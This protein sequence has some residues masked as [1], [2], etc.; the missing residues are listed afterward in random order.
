MADNRVL[1]FYLT[2]NSGHHRAALALQE[3]LQAARGVDA[4]LVNTLRLTHPFLENIVLSTYV[5]M[6]KSAPEVWDYLYDNHKVK[7]R[8]ELFQK[9]V[10]KVKAHK[11]MRLLSEHAPAVLV[12]TQAFPC[13][14]IADC[15]QEKNLQTPLIAVITD[16][17][18]HAYWV[19]DQVDLYIVPSEDARDQLLSYG[20]S[21]DKVRVLGIPISPTFNH[22]PDPHAIKRKFGFSGALPMVLI[23]GGGRGLGP[24]ERVVE[25]LDGVDVPF[26]MLALTGTNR[27]LESCLKRKRK[28]M[29]KRLGVQGHVSDVASLMAVSDVLISKPGGLTISEAMASTLP[30]I[31][32]DPLPGQEARNARFLLRNKACVLADTA[33][34]AAGQVR[35][36]LKNPRL[37]EQA[38]ENIRRL[39]R[40]NAAEWIAQ[41]IVNRIPACV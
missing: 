25:E 31:L 33:R 37:L 30:V 36:W 28:W 7:Q 16:Y 11:L 10:H 12:C 40:P 2:E 1:L 8:I 22:R 32:L 24:I 21:K 14:L 17:M 23:M 5:G 15:K 18:A 4:Q 35:H 9:L 3:A 6:L 29:Q 27:R 41:E 34:D 38:R 26:E 13:G 20:V 39:R 19:Y